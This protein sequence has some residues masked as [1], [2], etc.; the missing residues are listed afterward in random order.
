MAK[1]ERNNI[2]LAVYYISTKP[3]STLS[4]SMENASLAWLM[5]SLEVTPSGNHYSLRLLN[6]QE[7]RHAR[8]ILPAI[9]D[10]SRNIRFRGVFRKKA[11]KRITSAPVVVPPI[12]TYIQHPTFAART[13][14]G[15]TFRL[16]W[17]KSIFQLTLNGL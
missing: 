3:I 9:G 4:L 1:A 16:N 12:E 2:T 5:D 15:S 10:A 17:I 11:A 7:F 6:A 8:R 14:T 13:A